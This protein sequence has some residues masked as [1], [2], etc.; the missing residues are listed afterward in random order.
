[1]WFL[2]RRKS[3]R[4]A[5]SWGPPPTPQRLFSMGLLSRSGFDPSALVF[6]VVDIETTGLSPTNDRIVEIAVVCVRSDGTVL[7]EYATLVDPGRDVGPTFIHHI[8]NEAVQGAPRFPDVM[9]AVLQRLNG[10]VLVA[11]N[12]SFEEG[13]IGAELARAGLQVPPIPA[14]CTLQ[15]SQQ[16]LTTPNHRLATCCQHVG[17]EL[18]DHHTALGDTRATA[19]LVS[20]LVRG[21]QGAKL[22][23]PTQPVHLPC[24]PCTASPRHRASKLRKGQEG[25]MAN[26]VSKLP[27][28]VGDIHPTAAEAYL[29]LLADAVS[30]G[31]IIGEEAKALAQ[32]A[33]RAGLGANHVRVLHHRFLE[34]LRAVA[35]E[36]GVVTAQE[37]RD[38]VKVATQ[39]GEPAYFEDLLPNAITA[40][41]LSRT[42]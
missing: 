16:L 10:A 38:L 37:R 11:H 2:K 40:P 41:A 1:M 42:Q 24:P 30:D 9:G 33:G 3:K 8:T 28:T 32:L 20:R 22:A 5:K 35:L 23:F 36:D 12:A 13:F 6:A 39:L 7:D 21:A 26:L 18:V 25:W 29:D 15:L 31:R 19:Q 4:A 27:V 34:G 17:V 14:L